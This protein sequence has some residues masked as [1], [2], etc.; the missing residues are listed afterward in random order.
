MWPDAHQQQCTSRECDAALCQVALPCGRRGAWLS[1]RAGLRRCTRLLKHADGH[2]L[3]VQ[4]AQ[5]KAI[6]RHAGARAPHHDAVGR[7]GRQVLAGRH[8][9]GQRAIVRSVCAVQ[10]CVF[11]ISGPVAASKGRTASAPACL[12]L[13]HLPAL[14]TCFV[15][16]GG[17]AQLRP[18]TQAPASVAAGG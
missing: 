4:G 14:S 7:R 6:R 11:N 13:S 1:S 8:A 18:P 15:V 10:R 17:L 9:A 3:T 5:A 12:V 16:Q 2:V